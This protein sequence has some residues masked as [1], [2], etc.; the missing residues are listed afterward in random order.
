MLGA[1]ICMTSLALVVLLACA[2]SNRHGNPIELLGETVAPP[3]PFD[4]LKLGMTVA[5]AKAAL[6]ELSG[7][8]DEKTGHGEIVVKDVPVTVVFDHAR[9]SQ[10]SMR[11]ERPTFEPE[12]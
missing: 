4:T 7:E 6:P 9:L 5:E 1:R 10:I 3:A 11:L 12:L 8:I 2:C